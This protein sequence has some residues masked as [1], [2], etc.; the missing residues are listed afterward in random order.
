MATV[1]SWARQ[2]LRALGLSAISESQRIANECL[3]VEY[4]ELSR[5]ASHGLWLVHVLAAGADE[6]SVLRNGGLLSAA[7]EVAA[8]PYFQPRHPLQV[9]DCPRR[10]IDERAH[11]MVP[12]GRRR[13]Q[14]RSPAVRVGSRI[15]LAGG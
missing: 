13:H 11:R 2:V 15:S 4:R 9:A 1:H 6:R 3:Q 8:L 7:A 14:A 12:H 10:K 5:A